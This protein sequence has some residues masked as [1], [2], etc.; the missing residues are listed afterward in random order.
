MKEAIRS[1]VAP[2]AR[3][4]KY[5]I[6]L[7]SDW[8]F[9]RRILVIVDSSSLIKLSVCSIVPTATRSCGY[10]LAG[11]LKNESD[12]NSQLAPTGDQVG[13]AI[14]LP[15]HLGP[16]NVRPVSP[17]WY[18]FDPSCGNG[19]R[20][21]GLVRLLGLGQLLLFDNAVDFGLKIVFL[22]ATRVA[23]NVLHFALCKLMYLGFPRAKQPLDS[24]WLTLSLRF[25]A[26]MTV[27]I[28]DHRQTLPPLAEGRVNE[29]V[30]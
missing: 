24:T 5:V 23:I 9:V 18:I 25:H 19:N 17:E 30:W 11:F 22:E 16:V 26:A 15:I 29:T 2:C 6:Y 10:K 14:D 28:C 12:L 3:T 4:L 7:F 1:N 20:N 13:P 27:Y 8:R 21:L